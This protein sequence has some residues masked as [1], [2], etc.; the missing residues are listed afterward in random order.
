MAVPKRK[1]SRAR[2]DNRR[3]HIRLAAIQTVQCPSCGEQMLLH[4]ACPHCGFYRG[5][6]AAQLKTKQPTETPAEG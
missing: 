6:D 5:R 2:R 4:R 1:K 3:A